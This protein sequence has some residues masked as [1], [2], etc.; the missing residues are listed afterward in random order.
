MFLEWFCLVI[1]DGCPIALFDHL[2]NFFP[3]NDHEVRAENQ[4]PMCK[5]KGLNCSNNSC[6]KLCHIE[7]AYDLSNNDQMQ[8]FGH[9]AVKMFNEEKN[10]ELQFVRVVSGSKLL[11]EDFFYLTLQAAEAGVMKIY[12]A[13]L[14]LPG[15]KKITHPNSRLNLFGHVVDSGRL[16]ILIDKRHEECTK[17][18]LVSEDIITANQQGYCR[19]KDVDNFIPAFLRY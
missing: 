17:E 14:F 2:E 1:D 13:E 16:S 3:Q 7:P 19:Y 6:I 11:R 15:K 18:I 10:A 12:Q 9:W 8:R 4:T 5:K